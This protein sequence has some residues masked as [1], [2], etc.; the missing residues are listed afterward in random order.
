[1]IC[2]FSR[3]SD[4]FTFGKFKGYSLS[5][6]IEINPSYIY[7]CLDTLPESFI[8]LDEAMEELRMIYS[9]FKIS[10]KFEQV[11][12]EMANHCINKYKRLGLIDDSEIN[13]SNEYE[14][15]SKYRGSYVQDVEGYSDQFIDD[16][17]EGQVDAYWN[18]D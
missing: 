5:D 16:V 6:V 12:S 10:P 14:T 13:N 4:Q 2:I 15:Y 11:R 18:I 9:T 1:M 7:W 3:L 17:F 8:I